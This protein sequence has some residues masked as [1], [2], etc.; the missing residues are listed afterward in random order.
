MS[1]KCLQRFRAIAATAT[2]L[3]VDFKRKISQHVEITDLGE[4][5]WLLG[6]EIH[7]DCEHCSIHLS[8]CY[9]DSIIHC[10]SLQDLKPVS[11]PMETNLHLSSSQSPLTTSAKHQEIISISTT[12]S[13]YVSATHTAKEALWLHSLITQLFSLNL[14]PTT[15][16][17]RQSVCDCTHS[18]PECWNCKLALIS[19]CHPG[20]VYTIKGH[21]LGHPGYSAISVFRV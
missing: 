15:L 2:A 20:P 3:I 13:E 9:I 19:C 7:H 6:I 12:E 14:D 8:Q 5:H 21:L 4:L 10:Y 18:G 1:S 16:F 17:F 11:T